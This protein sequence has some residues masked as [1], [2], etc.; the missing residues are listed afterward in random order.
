MEEIKDD[1]VTKGPSGINTQIWGEKKK[2]TLLE[3]KQSRLETK[4]N[5]LS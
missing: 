3:T 5:V 2:I 4:C 1:H